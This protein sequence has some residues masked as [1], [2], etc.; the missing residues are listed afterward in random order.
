[1]TAQ[2]AQMAAKDEEM[3]KLALKAFEEAKKREMER[4]Q[5][6]LGMHKQEVMK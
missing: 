3:D 2:A 4:K 5:R 6:A 1:M